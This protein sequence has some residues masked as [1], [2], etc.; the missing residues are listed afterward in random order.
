MD[1]GLTIIGMMSGTS[2]DGIDACL[3][4]IGLESASLRATDT[5]Q[6]RGSAAIQKNEESSGLLRHFVPRN[7]N[8]FIFQVLGTHSITYPDEIARKLISIANNNRTTADICSM[9]FAVGKLFAK[10]ANE[11]VEKTNFSKLKSNC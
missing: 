11:L 9:D 8:T 7:D 6:G 4:Q 5:P 2:M 3:V 1:N 10:C